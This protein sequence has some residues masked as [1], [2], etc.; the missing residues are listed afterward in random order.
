MRKIAKRNGKEF[1][2]FLFENQ[3][4]GSPA[5][6]RDSLKDKLDKLGVEVEQDSV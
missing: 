4:E 5:D 6:E 3:K 1:P 2:A